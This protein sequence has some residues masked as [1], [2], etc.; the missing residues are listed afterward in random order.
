[1]SEETG[2]CEHCDHVELVHMDGYCTECEA[3]CEFV[4]LLTW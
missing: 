2:R 3:E 4:E 1:M